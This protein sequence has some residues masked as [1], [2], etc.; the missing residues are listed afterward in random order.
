MEKVIYINPEGVIDKSKL[1]ENEQK[2]ICKLCHGIVYEP[3]E[4][5]CEHIFCKSC[6]DNWE[7]NLKNRCPTCNKFI[8][9]KSKI[10]EN[11]QIIL[12]NLTFSEKNKEYLYH[13]YINFLKFGTVMDL[14]DEVDL[15]DISKKTKKKFICKA[16]GKENDNLINEMTDKYEEINKNLKEELKKIYQY[17]RRLQ[18]EI[19]EKKFGKNMP[20]STLI[21]KCQHFSG[22][23]KPIFDCCNTAY[24]C[25][26]CHD[27]NECHT[28][29]ISK[30][31]ICL[32]CACIYEGIECT[33]C[34]VKQVYQKK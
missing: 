26:I 23:Y 7:Q 10:A 20:P 4:L 17:K 6:L 18:G 15:D 29:Q 27:E 25:Y 30:K 16:C 2:I 1:K 8:Y 24:G 28:H 3:V 9:K 31:V 19:Y 33:N 32:L 11:I 5:F 13:D 34:K 22:N 21:E 12:D 14:N